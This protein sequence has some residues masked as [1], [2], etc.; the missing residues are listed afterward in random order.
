M[1]TSDLENNFWNDDRV[2]A[3]TS[4]ISNLLETRLWAPEIDRVG[5][6]FRLLWPISA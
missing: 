4:L 5:S 2:R 3:S 1:K 6:W